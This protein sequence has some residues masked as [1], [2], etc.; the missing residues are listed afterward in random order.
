GHGA[1]DTDS[2]TSLPL[3]TLERREFERD[4]LEPWS[5]APWLDAVMTAHVL[6]PS[7]GAGPASISPWSRTLLDAA[8]GGTYRGLVITD[9]LD[10]AAVAQ[11]PG[12]GEAVVRAVEAGAHLLCLGTSIRR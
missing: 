3:I 4:H 10:M 6:V 9:A 2:H 5:I 8:V 7:L 1:T 12:G 11:D